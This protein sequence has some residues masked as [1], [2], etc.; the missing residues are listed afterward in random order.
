MSW[1]RPGW[2]EHYELNYLISEAKAIRVRDFVQTYLDFDEYSVGR[3]NF[4][5]PVYT[6]YLDSDDLKFYWRA[7]NDVEH[8][9]QLRV[10]YF[11]AD[12]DAPVSLEI[13]RRTADGV[14]RKR[15]RVRR[16]A[17]SAALDGQLPGMEQLL[18]R[19]PKH[20]DALQAFVEQATRFQVRPKL[21]VVFQRESYVSGDDTVRLT[22]DRSVVCEAA[23]TADLKTSLDDPRLV[24]HPWVLLELNFNERYPDWFRELVRHFNLT[25]CEIDKYVTGILAC[26][27]FVCAQEGD[28]RSRREEIAPPDLRAS[29]GFSEGERD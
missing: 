11:S 1:Q 28:R 3:P 23:S 4:S 20:L 13:K 12:P 16:E 22:M 29:E 5:F 26:G 17:V 18:S 27:H 24:F 7:V 9:C 2:E 25:E 15:S 21:R 6:L 14:L 19:H 8:R 10:R